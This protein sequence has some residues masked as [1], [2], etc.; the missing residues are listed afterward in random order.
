MEDHKDDSPEEL[1]S[2][3]NQFNETTKAIHKNLGKRPFHIHRGI[4]AAVFDSVYVAFAKKLNTIP[5]DITERYKKLIKDPQ[6]LQYVTA[7]T[8]DDDVV[9]KRMEL[10][11]KVLFG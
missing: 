1:L 11:E 8:T 3:K 5:D 6:F 4:N 10:A 7:G 2:F 9:K